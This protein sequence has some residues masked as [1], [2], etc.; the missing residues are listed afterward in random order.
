MMTQTTILDL[1]NQLAKALGMS[2]RA[3]TYV[4]DDLSR[5]G[6]IGQQHESATVEDATRLLISIAGDF[7][8]RAPH[9]AVERF[10][11]LPLARVQLITEGPGTLAWVTAPADDSHVAVIRETLGDTFGT[12]FANLVGDYTFLSESATVPGN[13]S[14]S[15]SPGRTCASLRRDK[16]DGI[17]M[18]HF[19]VP[20]FMGGVAPFGLPPASPLRTVEIPAAIFQVLRDALEGS[21]HSWFNAAEGRT[22]VYARRPMEGD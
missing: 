14:L 7:D 19:D 8:I 16:A 20:D 17:V 9:R 5:A 10:W 18:L 21:P 22:D 1:T 2:A 11:H 15:G 13:I 12:A 6:M 3:L 4:A